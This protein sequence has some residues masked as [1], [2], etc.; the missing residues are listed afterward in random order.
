MTKKIVLVTTVSMFKHSYVFW[1]DKDTDSKGVLDFIGDDDVEE[2]SQEWMGEQI[3]NYRDIDIKEYLQ[4]FDKEND[5][6]KD[7]SSEKKISHILDP[8]VIEQKKY[9]RINIIK[10]TKEV[11]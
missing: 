10:T 8:E 5:Y 2:M 7:W 4:I 11:E 9:Q 6:L 3:V 1:E